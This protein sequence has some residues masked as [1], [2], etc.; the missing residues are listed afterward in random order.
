M[1]VEGENKNL[2]AALRLIQALDTVKH[3]HLGPVRHSG[4]TKGC[5]YCIAE[6]AIQGETDPF[7]LERL[8]ERVG[9]DDHTG[10]P[11]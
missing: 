10:E 6:L 8:R 4:L 2:T 9:A 3:G 7:E 5:I 1:S 11:T